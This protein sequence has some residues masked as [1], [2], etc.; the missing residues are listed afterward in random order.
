MMDFDVAE[1]FG[2]AEYKAADVGKRV[3]IAHDFIDDEFSHDEKACG[4][5]C[6]GLPYDGFGH[7]LVDPGSK[8]SEQVLLGV[9]VVTVNDV[10]AFF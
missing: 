10:E 5:Q 3:G 2:C 7:F 9:L 6:L 4:A 8:A 1:I